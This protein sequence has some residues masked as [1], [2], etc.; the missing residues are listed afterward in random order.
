VIVKV[1]QNLLVA[2]DIQSDTPATVAVELEESPK[3]IAAALAWLGYSRAS[4]HALHSL[5]PGRLTAEMKR[6]AISRGPWKNGKSAFSS[7]TTE[8]SVPR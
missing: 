8:L 5:S 1:G 6:A 7:L 3:E 4:L 2:E